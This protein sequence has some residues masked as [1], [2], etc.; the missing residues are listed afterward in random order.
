MC[1][2]SDGAS[3]VIGADLLPQEKRVDRRALSC[4]D[5][6]QLDRIFMARFNVGDQSRQCEVAVKV[7]QNLG[8]IEPRPVRS[9]RAAS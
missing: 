2:C 5:L 8:S 1:R 4:G 7:L 9:T 3:T 6:L